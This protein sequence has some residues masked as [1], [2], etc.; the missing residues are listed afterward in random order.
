MEIKSTC[1]FGHECEKAIDNKT[2]ERCT[3]YIHL[4]GKNP[5]TEEDIDQY[6]CAIGWL[7]IL[8]IE[9]AQTVRGASAAI[10]SFRNETVRGQAEF[11]S[12]LAAVAQRKLSN[13]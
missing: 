11:N 1:P 4:R 12:M 7:P 9:N 3:F 2:I 5:Q 13:G 10:E 8:L 6:G